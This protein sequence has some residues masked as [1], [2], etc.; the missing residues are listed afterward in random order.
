MS[1]VAIICVLI[2]GVLVFGLG[3]GVSLNRLRKAKSFGVTEDPECLLYKFSRAHVNTIEYAPY[4]AI[5]ML[6]HGAHQPALWL[7]AVM[8]LA[9][10]SRLLTVVGL[11]AFKSLKTTNKVRFAGAVG[12]YTTGLILS[13]SM[14]L[15]V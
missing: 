8:V 12:T 2:L 14:L 15:Y 6:F 4:F 7:E 9:T 1:H 5:L 10:V 13:L 3:F 11:I